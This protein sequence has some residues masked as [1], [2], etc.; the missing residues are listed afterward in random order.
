MKVNLVAKL[1]DCAFREIMIRNLTGMEIL[2]A[3][4]G[5]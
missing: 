5:Q 4:R 2:V 3:V 1:E